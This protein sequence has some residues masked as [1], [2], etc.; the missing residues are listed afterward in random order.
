MDAWEILT[1]NS[2]LL[3]GDAWEHLN[4]QGGSGGTY[5]I[6]NID[7]EYSLENMDIEIVQP[8]DIEYDNSTYELEVIDNNIDIEVDNGDN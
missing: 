5:M 2:T 6:E 3:T 8:I 1:S 4:A 7:I